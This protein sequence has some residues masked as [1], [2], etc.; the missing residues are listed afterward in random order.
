MANRITY[1]IGCSMVAWCFLLA[2]PTA[3]AQVVTM[4][5]DTSTIA[6]GDQTQLTI[7]ASRGITQSNGSFGWPVFGDTL[8]GGLE[9]LRLLSTDTSLTELESGESAFAISKTFLVTCWDS[10]LVAIPPVTLLWNQDSLFSNALELL[11]LMPQPGEA[12]KIAASADIRETQWSWQEKLQRWMPWIAGAT[13]F[14]LLLLL[15]IR[16]LQRMEPKER[17]EEKIPE[18]P[19]ELAHVVALRE[20]ERIQLDAIWKRGETK[21]HHAEISEALRRYL[22]NRYQFPALERSTEE[23]QR[24]IAQL[25]LRKEE[26]EI[27][28]EV[29]HLTDLVKF[30]KWKPSVSDHERMVQRSIAFV[31]HTLP[32]EPEANE[33]QTS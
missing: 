22:E 8:N 31:E 1:L 19:K 26:E 24:G 33:I 14:L 15:I 32:T 4:R 30:A 3:S 23:I 2:T 6:I 25:P 12:G 13:I 16:R 5:L 27:V 20:L 11:V 28:I 18:K 29:L 10:G 21:R 7:A 9:L 17:S